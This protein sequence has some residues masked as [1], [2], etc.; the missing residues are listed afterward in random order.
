MKKKD[1]RIEDA[2]NYIK[3]IS[4]YNNE[5]MQ[6]LCKRIYEFLNEVTQKYKDKNIL[7]VTHGSASIPIKCYFMNYPL[8]NLVDREKIKGLKNCEVIEFEI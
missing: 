1:P 7:L 6:D 2:Y 4:M 3:N 8:E 5:P